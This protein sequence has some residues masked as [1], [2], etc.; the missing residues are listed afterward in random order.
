MA[1]I[2]EGKHST[3]VCVLNL[4]LTN[5]IVFIIGCGCTQ[6][7]QTMYSF[8][9]F[10]L[11]YGLFPVLVA[12]GFVSY[13]CLLKALHYHS[14][15]VPPNRSSWLSAIDRLVRSFTSDTYIISTAVLVGSHLELLEE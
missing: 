12:F 6:A 14:A 4:C 5:R 8:R 11:E 9:C 10:L 7:L 1:R 3:I 2:W 15:P 13:S